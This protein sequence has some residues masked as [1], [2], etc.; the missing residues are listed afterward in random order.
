MTEE[1]KNKTKSKTKSRT[2]SKKRI[3]TWFE[4]SLFLFAL[5]IIFFLIFQRGGY[6]FSEKTEKITITDNPTHG[7][8]KATKRIYTPKP[9]D[10]DQS[11]DKVL[12]KIAKKFSNNN[13][14]NTKEIKALGLPKD[15]AKYLQEQ[16]DQHEFDK[17]IQ[18]AK[19]WFYVLKTSHQ[20]YTKVKSLF[21][22]IDKKA[23]QENNPDQLLNNQSD[24]NELYKKMEELFGITPEQVAS[25]TRRGQRTL[26]D[27]AAFV[28]E[29]KKKN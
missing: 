3:L 7:K 19:D 5:V 23:V 6:K 1:L 18:S 11:V 16:K 27:W 2:K 10:E 24:A 25:F 21:E 9:S 26:S 8:H 29:E 14:I 28:E 17:T 13:N 15:E 4:K 22:A 20:T 12:E